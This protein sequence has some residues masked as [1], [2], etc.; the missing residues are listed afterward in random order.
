VA[1]GDHRLAGALAERRGLASVA[2]EP[3]ELGVV[4]LARDSVVGEP[5]LE[6][7]IGVAH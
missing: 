4:L 1:R 6:L 2:S 5:E 7:G 3:P